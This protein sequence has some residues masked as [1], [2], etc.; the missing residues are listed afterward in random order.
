MK[1]QR[2]IKLTTHLNVICKWLRAWYTW[3]VGPPTGIKRDIIY[4]MLEFSLQKGF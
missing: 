1:L 2:V 4:T 3:A